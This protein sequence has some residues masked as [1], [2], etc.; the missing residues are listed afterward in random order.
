MELKDD[1]LK[2][3]KAIAEFLGEEERRVF[4]L[5]EKK[6]IPGFKYGGLWNARKSTLLQHIEKLEAAAVAEA[7]A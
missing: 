1:K 7:V 5:L 3:A 4:Y 2:G 6:Q